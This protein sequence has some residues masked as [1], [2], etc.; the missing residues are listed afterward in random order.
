[1]TGCVFGSG[2][3]LDTG[4]DIVIVGAFLNLKKM[5]TTKMIKKRKTNFF[6]SDY[7]TANVLIIVRLDLKQEVKPDK[8][9]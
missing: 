3:T 2:M 7:C 9:R 5:K 1:M 8:R 6:I 4:N